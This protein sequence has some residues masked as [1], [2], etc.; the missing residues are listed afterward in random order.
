MQKNLL[1]F[2]LFFLLRMG[3][4]TKK[5]NDCKKNHKIKVAKFAQLEVE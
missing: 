5:S 2:F 3:E 4:G 1:R